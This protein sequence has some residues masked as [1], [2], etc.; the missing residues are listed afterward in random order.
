MQLPKAMLKAIP[1]DYHDTSKG[2][3]KLLWEDEWRA[4]GITQVRV[5]AAAPVM[6]TRRTRTTLTRAESRLGAL[7]GPRARAAHSALQVC[8]SR[9]PARGRETPPLT[10]PGAR[11]TTSR[12]SE[13]CTIAAVAPTAHVRSC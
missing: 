7:R 13:R 10:L 12:R 5:M 8:D 3:L 6:A 2:M 11:S 1:K 9:W 4:I